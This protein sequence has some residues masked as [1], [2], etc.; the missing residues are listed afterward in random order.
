MCICC[1]GI[2]KG[3]ELAKGLFGLFTGSGIALSSQDGEDARRL[4]LERSFLGAFA[5]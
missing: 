5:G 4:D 2:S 1:L 3:Y